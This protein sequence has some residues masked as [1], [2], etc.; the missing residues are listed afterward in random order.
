MYHLAACMVVE[1][2]PAM[3]H[4]AFIDAQ[5]APTLCTRQ[6]TSNQASHSLH[7]SSQSKGQPNHIKLTWPDDL[8]CRPLTAAVAAAG[9]GHITLDGSARMRERP[10]QDLV[11]GL[12]Q[13]GVDAQCTAGTGCPP[14][15]VNAQGLPSGKVG[16]LL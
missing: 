11:D 15:T 14:V 16:Q 12:T 8:G 5:A 1:S 3:H 10:I 7:A 9:R 6:D 4:T 2:T 13:L